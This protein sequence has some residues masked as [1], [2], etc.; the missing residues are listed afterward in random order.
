MQGLLVFI[1]LGCS[2]LDTPRTFG[3][4]ISTAES[5]GVDGGK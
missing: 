2:F 1:Y 5:N 3:D 4:N